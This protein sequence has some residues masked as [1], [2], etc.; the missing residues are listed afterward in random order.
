[1]PINNEHPLSL[2][3]AIVRKNNMKNIKKKKY[4]DIK[5]LCKEYKPISQ[6]AL[7]LPP[8]HAMLVEKLEHASYLLHGESEVQ[9]WN[10]YSKNVKMVY[11]SDMS[12]HGRYAM[13]VRMNIQL[14]KDLAPML[15][16]FI[17]FVDRMAKLRM[18]AGERKE[19]R[20]R[21]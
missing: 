19:A 8:T 15:Q 11:L 2:T 20:K 14:G 7:A 9:L 13:T 4:P 5:H 16:W 18:S 1:M 6:S 10:Q 17:V 12:R 21:R 3:L